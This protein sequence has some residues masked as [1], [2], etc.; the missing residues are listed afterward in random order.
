MLR[1]SWE[2]SN[3]RAHQNL[4]AVLNGE[5][6]RNFQTSNGQVVLDLSPLVQ[7]VS[8]RFDSGRRLV[9]H[10]LWSVQRI[11]PASKARAV[12]R[13]ASAASSRV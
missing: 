6:V 2:E 13:T 4:L 5:D 9:G 3:R 8:D 7:R 12:P 11:A 1:S 10:P